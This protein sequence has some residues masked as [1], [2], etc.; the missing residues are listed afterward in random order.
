MKL[1]V[2]NLF[3]TLGL[4]TVLAIAPSTVSANDIHI[5]VQGLNVGFHGDNYSRKKYRKRNK[6]Y[7]N[8]RYY[9][10]KHY[11]N[12]NYSNGR[13]YNDY[14][15]DYNRSYNN[16]YIDND[17][18]NNNYRSNNYNSQV[19]PVNGYSSYYDKSRDCYEHKGHFHC[20]DY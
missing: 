19:C 1:S 13:Y 20:S 9:S 14:N 17:Y 2:K 3:A 18:R 15:R 10:K 11:N 8:K 7:Y 4:L 12:N 5:S 16:S 6:Q